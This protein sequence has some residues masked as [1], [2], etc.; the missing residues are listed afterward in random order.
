MTDLSERWNVRRGTIVGAGHRRL[1]TNNQDALA[2]EWH[3]TAGN[4]FGIG[5]V[6]DGCSGEKRRSKNEVGAELLTQ[7]ILS[8]TKLLLSGGAPTAEIPTILYPRCV[9]YVGTV[10]RATCVDS[11]TA[12]RFIEKHFLATVLG[13]VL[14]E[15]DLVVFSAGDGV[16][17]VDDTIKV[18]DQ[19][20][21]PLY[22]AYHQIDR[23][24]LDEPAANLPNSFHTTR[25][26]NVSR[27]IIATDGVIVR[28]NMSTEEIASALEPLW[29][30]ES[31]ASAG[32]QWWLN[33]C[34]E[35]AE[36][37]HDDCSVIAARLR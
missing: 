22:L 18:I 34:S 3:G 12:Q 24:T 6:S 28:K 16:V 5:I 11:R 10:A 36:P 2:F 7:F 26:N 21:K 9:A 30:Y 35:G 29:Q 19:N 15:N 8:E 17:A 23:E 31:T 33:K 4:N 27:F 13:F 25:F 37:F 14:S 32:L 1:R 20:D